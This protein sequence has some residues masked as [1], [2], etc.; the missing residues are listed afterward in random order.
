MIEYKIP[1]GGSE[2]K[3]QIPKRFNVE[4]LDGQFVPEISDEEIKEALRC[5]IGSPPLSEI[6][7][8]KGGDAVVVVSDVTR[9]VPYKKFL[10]YVIKELQSAGI[11]SDR[12]T[13]LVATGAHRENSKEE[14]MRMFGH[15]IVNNIR[16]ANH[17]ATNHKDMVDLGKTQ[18]G[19]PVIINKLFA[20]AD[21]RILTGLIGLHQT[22][23]FSGGRKSVV[24]GIASDK[25]IR[26]HHSF[27][28]R[29]R[30]AVLGKLK[31]NLF[32]KSAMEAAK[33]VGVDFIVNVVT[34]SRKQL[35]GLVAGDLE[36]AWLEGVKLCRQTRQ[37]PILQRFDVAITTPGGYPRDMDLYQSQKAL[38]PA[39]SAV[40]AGGNV[41]LVAECRDGLGGK[42]ETYA[43]WLREGKTPAE[44]MERFEREG[45]TEASSKAYMFARALNRFKITVVTKNIETKVLNDMFFDHAS[46]VQE[47]I[48]RVLNGRETPT[49]L[50]ILPHG[51]SI[52]ISC[53]NG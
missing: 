13:I 17:S 50:C 46:T 51:S 11:S 30:Q 48:N 32:H 52:A 16:I 24:P 2:V 15:E 43:G 3:F 38:S 35:I 12:V 44:V 10:P 34:N 22:A 4:I 7:R 19:L 33:I 49:R 1:Y 27:P 28:F 47:A 29:S 23:G 9:P 41:V 18:S 53:S 21:I 31:E 8:K 39:E 14:I 26:I 5:P 20:E 36:S 42:T 40:Y 37:I 25:L 45:W 6:A